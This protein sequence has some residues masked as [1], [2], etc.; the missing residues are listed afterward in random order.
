[1]AVE[2]KWKANQEKVAFTKQFPGLTLD[3]KGCEGKTVRAVIP[4]TGKQGAAVVVFT[5]G[6][7]TV[8][9]PLMPEPWELGQALVDA[10]AHLEPTHTDAYIEYD[11]LVKKDRDALKSARVEKIVGAIQNNL[12]QIPELKERLKELVKEWK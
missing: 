2:E 11:R 9:P 12:E 7:F 5:D 1:M 10:R 8:V 6:S 4:L 3:W